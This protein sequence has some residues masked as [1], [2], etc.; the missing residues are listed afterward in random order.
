MQTLINKL[1]QQA[2]DNESADD[3][4]VT[5]QLLH[6][7]VSGEQKTEV[8]AGITAIHPVRVPEVNNPGLATPLQEKISDKI[9]EGETPNELPE[10]KT[11]EVL[12]VDE[13]EIEKELD[14]IKK[15]AQQ[16]NKIS[17]HVNTMLLFDPVDDVPNLG[18]QPAPEQNTINEA[19]PSKV[20]LNEKLKEVRTELS[21]KLVDSPIK[22]LK[23]AIG[24]N[25]RYLF[26]NELFRGDE[27]MYERSMKTINGFTIFP[28]AEYW[29]RRELKLKLGWKNDDPVVQQFDQ[30]I[31]RRF[32]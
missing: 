27:P 9:P 21:E 30:L 11:V 8:A 16:I 29:I 32:S 7:E 25:D 5:I 31:R 6:R 18:H 12:Q 19:E 10:E 24:V 1:Q 4:L 15:N 17:G 13:K 14:E 2:N 23:K 26:I 28:E 20:S 22:D 3:L